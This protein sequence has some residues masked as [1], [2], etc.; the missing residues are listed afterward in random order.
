MTGTVTNTY[1]LLC[2]LGFVSVGLRSFN[3]QDDAIGNDGEE[4]GVL[5]VR[6]FFEN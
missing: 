6:I 3:G 2:Q 4:D 5:R 1:K